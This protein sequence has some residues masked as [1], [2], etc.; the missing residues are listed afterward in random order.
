ML[1]ERLLLIHPI[2]LLDRLGRN[3]KRKSE[4]KRLATDRPTTYLSPPSFVSALGEALAGDGPVTSPCD[5]SGVP[6]QRLGTKPFQKDGNR[7]VSSRI[8]ISADKSF[9]CAPMMRFVAM[10]LRRMCDEGT[11]ATINSR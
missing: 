11:E 9:V 2:Q 5:T 7:E 6:R 4:R 3:R 1:D 10:T 8:A